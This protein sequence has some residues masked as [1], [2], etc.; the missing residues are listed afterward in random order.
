[1]SFFSI[2][3]DGR[4]IVTSNHLNAGVLR[5]RASK[6]VKR[7][8]EYDPRELLSAHKSELWQCRDYVRADLNQNDLA[9]FDRRVY[10]SDIQLKIEVGLLIPEEE[11]ASHKEPCAS[12]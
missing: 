6:I 12:V 3:V 2:L 1:M 11:E 10:R 5:S 7:V 9:D 4:V 8:V